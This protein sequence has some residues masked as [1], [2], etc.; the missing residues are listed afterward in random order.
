MA[1]GM[2]DHGLDE[3]EDSDQC[4]VLLITAPWATVNGPSVQLSILK[5]VLQAAGLKCDVEYANLRFLEYIPLGQYNRFLRY[6]PLGEWLFNLPL[7]SNRKHLTSDYLDYINQHYLEQHAAENQLGESSATKETNLLTDIFGKGYIETILG[8]KREIVPK[9]VSDVAERALGHGARVIGFTSTFNQNVPSLSIAKTIKNRSHNIKIVFGGG[10][11]EGIMGPTLLRSFPFVDYVVSGEGEIAFPRLLRGIF[12]G[13]NSEELKEIGGVA[14]RNG[15][16]VWSG[17]QAESPSMDEI[18]LMDCGDYYDVAAELR[19]KGIAVPT[20][21]VF[22]ECSRGCWWG[23]HSQCTF[24]GL[25]GLNIRYR[26]KSPERV[27]Q[28]VISLSEKHRVLFFQAA[29]NILNPA[30]FAALLP[31]FRKTGIDFQFYFE[32]KATMTKNQIKLLADC[33]VTR[34]Q[35]GIE[36]LSTHVLQLMSKGTNML[37]NVQAL[38]WFEEFHIWPD[39]NFL[40][41]FP[42]EKEE[43]YLGIEALLPLIYHLPP[44]STEL[45]RIELDRFS[46]NFDFAKEL[47]FRN[48]MPS[49]DYFYIYDLDE[50]VLR[51]LVYSFDY[52]LEGGK[53]FL[54]QV[55]RI[56]RLIREWNAKYNEEPK[57]SKLTYRKGFDFVEILDRRRSETKRIVLSGSA[58]EVFISCDRI[59]SLGGLVESLRARRDSSPES[60][61]V[62]LIEELRAKGLIIEEG[63]K[64]LA[65]ATA[66]SPSQELVR[67]QNAGLMG[68]ETGRSKVLTV[69]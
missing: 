69:T 20:G 3:V 51:D 67:T 21:P 55:A 18:P 52:E 42:N 64:Y 34:L 27:F 15:A 46:P 35:P 7:S 53:L 12:N 37:Q 33:G 48:V 31:K 68:N 24:C 65:L 8:L 32:V 40:I 30:F 61:M 1:W 14:L 26:S 29:D 11:C 9:F 63:E 58:A 57:G 4:D 28:E 36:S 56:N 41:G 49:R 38:K 23:Q 17:G 43:D 54:P 44:P 13:V 39:W 5:P 66:V 6:L 59:T 47:G 2:S 22:F 62:D 60:H 45:N 25:N 19:E 10:N 16:E 50:Q